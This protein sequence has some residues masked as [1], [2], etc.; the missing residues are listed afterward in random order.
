MSEQARQSLRQ[1]GRGLA[2]TM[3]IGGAGAFEASLSSSLALHDVINIDN[4]WP[5]FRL[6]VT[7]FVVSALIKAM[8]FL[9]RDP[10]PGDDE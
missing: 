6:A 1:W 2:S 9:K 3:I 7:A 10:L 5:M 4:P 8:E